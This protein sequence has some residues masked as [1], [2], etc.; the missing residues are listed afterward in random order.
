MTVSYVVFY[1][2]FIKHAISVFKTSAILGFKHATFDKSQQEKEYKFQ[3][4]M[5]TFEYAIICSVLQ[6]MANR[7]P[8]LSLFDESKSLYSWE[9]QAGII[10]E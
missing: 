1:S 9:R 3:N 2:Y 4:Y 5:K 10:I 7:C 8:V 6:I